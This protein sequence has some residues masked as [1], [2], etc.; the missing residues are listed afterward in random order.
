MGRN[1]GDAFDGMAGAFAHPLS[2][3]DAARFRRLH[4][5]GEL[6]LELG[7]LVRQPS[8]RVHNRIQPT[9]V[10]RTTGSE[11]SDGPPGWLDGT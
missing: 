10:T 6:P 9:A 7:P 1:G 8:R 5:V 3:T 2:E 11:P 4:E